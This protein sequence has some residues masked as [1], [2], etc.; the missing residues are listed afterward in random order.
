MVTLES[1]SRSL[2]FWTARGNFKTVKY[3]LYLNLRPRSFNSPVPVSFDP[4]GGWG[5]GEYKYKW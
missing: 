1:R 4:V 2:N 3:T 5:V